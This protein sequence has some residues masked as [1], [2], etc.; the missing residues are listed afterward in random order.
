MCQLRKKNLA[1][2][3]ASVVEAEKFLDHPRRRPPQIIENSTRIYYAILFT[4][5]VFYI[6]VSQVFVDFLQHYTTVTTCGVNCLIQGYLWKRAG[7]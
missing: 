7:A 2:S 3:V 5:T 6:R 1:N 4:S